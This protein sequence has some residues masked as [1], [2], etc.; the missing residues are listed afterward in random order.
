LYAGGVELNLTAGHIHQA[1][2]ISGACATIWP[3]PWPD[4]WFVG[5]LGYPP[6]ATEETVAGDEVAAVLESWAFQAHS[7]WAHGAGPLHRENPTLE[8]VRRSLG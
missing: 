6:R 4:R 7:P 3:T 8:A 2:S 1:W 5:L